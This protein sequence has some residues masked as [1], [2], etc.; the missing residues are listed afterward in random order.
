MKSTKDEGLVRLQEQAKIFGVRPKHAL[1]AVRLGAELGLTPMISL[2]KVRF[3]GRQATL[4]PLTILSIVNASGKLEDLL[5]D[6]DEQVCRVA[7]RRCGR[8]AH[9]ESFSMEDAERLGLLE[10]DHWK[11]YPK[12][13]RKM[14]AVAIC[15]RTVFPE[16][17]GGFLTPEEA[18]A[19]VD[20]NGE[21]ISTS[22]IGKAAKSLGKGA[23]KAASF[24]Y[25]KTAS[26][27]RALKK[28]L[29][30]KRR[31]EAAAELEPTERVIP[32][33]RTRKS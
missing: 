17:V 10:F 27:G 19:E 28:N 30:M 24:I 13:L 15:S 5:I 3:V 7:M 11:R 4:A 1:S 23:A 25:E 29:L 20:E 26:F 2:I 6:D 9:T 21:M 32:F 33:S 16:L 22:P 8:R 31:A 14:R 18:G 12:S